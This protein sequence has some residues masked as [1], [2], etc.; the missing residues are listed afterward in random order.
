MTN[1]QEKAQAENAKAEA[2]LTCG[3]VMPISAIDGCGADH[4][5][6]VKQILIDAI[7]SIE[8]PRF[9]ARLVSDADDVGV[10]QKRIVQG[11]YNSD[12]VVCDVSAKN[13]NVMF[14]LGMRLA[15]D[16][17]TVIVKDDKTDYSFDTGVIEH[18]SYPRD[19]RF[20][21]I[22]AFKKQLA[23]KVAATYA[24]SKDDPGHST[25]LKSFGTFKVANLE[26]K[27]AP[28]EQ[29]LLETIQDM[30]REIQRELRQFRRAP[31]RMESRSD[32]DPFLF[33]AL[34]TLGRHEPELIQEAN[35][36]LITRLATMYPDI[37]TRYPSRSELLAALRPACD[38]M[39]K[40]E[41][42]N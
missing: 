7:D 26:Q 17:P 30:Q 20:A 42:R 2:Q 3:L 31:V 25:F 32:P 4:W 34:I 11:V 39:R 22:V 38:L 18:I 13:P 9:H 35:D 10:I 41:R 29:V 23:D 15:F 5:G 16:K 21:R 6:E 37:A 14:E 27:E 12:V 28:T 36:H 19:L 8:A 40:L 33:D 24:A 1:P